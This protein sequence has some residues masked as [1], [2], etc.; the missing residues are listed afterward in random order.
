MSKYTP[1][2]CVQTLPRR[3][4]DAGRLQAARVASWKTTLTPEQKTNLARLLEAGASRRELKEAVRG[5][6]GSRT[7]VDFLMWG[8][9]PQVWLDRGALLNA[10][11]PCVPY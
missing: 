9:D 5:C 3:N 10:E 2:L 8:E 6:G 7:F 4:S 1:V 11:P